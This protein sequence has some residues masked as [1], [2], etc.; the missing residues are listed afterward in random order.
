[1]TKRWIGPVLVIAMVAFSLAVY[2]SLPAEVPTHWGWGGEVDD[3]SSRA[4]GAFMLPG[5]ALALWLLLPALRKIDPRR[6]HYE[7]FDETF[8]LIVNMILGFMAAMHVLAL[9]AALGWPVNMGRAVNVLA[10]VMLMGLGNYLP[11]VRSNWWI[12]IRTP[13]TLESERVW[14]ET[15]R[16]A[17]FAFVGAGAITVVTAFLPAEVGTTVMMVAIA[18]AAL[19]PTVYSFVLYRREKSA[20]RA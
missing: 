13:W 10:G 20:G 2:G 12:G 8:W 11:R 18:T 9:G 19:V 15:H 5:I 7:R 4:F 14:R 3:W 16:V 1:M 17:G 6:T